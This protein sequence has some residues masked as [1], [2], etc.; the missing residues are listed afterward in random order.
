M[1]EAPLS[2][3]GEF[4]RVAVPVHQRRGRCLWRALRAVRLLP[5]LRGHCEAIVDYVHALLARD[6]ADEEALLRPLVEGVPVQTE[7]VAGIARE[8]VAVRRMT[9]SASW[10]HSLLREV[11]EGRRRV[12]VRL[13]GRV[14][15]IRP[16]AV[17]TLIRLLEELLG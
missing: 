8:G 5:Q 4:E 1:L 14:S 15:S 9:S 2:D 17:V 10:E 7:S 6:G 13:A 16:E 12:A 11:P 3:A